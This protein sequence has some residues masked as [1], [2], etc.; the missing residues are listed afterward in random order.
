MSAEKNTQYVLCPK[1]GYPNKL[2]SI[3]C[4]FCQKD[5]R[6]AKILHFPSSSDP[7]TR[8]GRPRHRRVGD[9]I[10]R[11]LVS[12]SLFMAGGYFFYIS[13][14]SSEFKLWLVSLLFFFYGFQLVHPFLR[15]PIDPQR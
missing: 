2:E 13:L 6:R 5:L 10:W 4:G 3:V 15:N 1:C 9:K 8:R 7:R 11:I 14:T 12:G